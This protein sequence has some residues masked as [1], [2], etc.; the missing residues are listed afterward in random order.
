MCYSTHQ[1]YFAISTRKKMLSAGVISNQQNEKRK[2]VLS[3]RTSQSISFGLWFIWRLYLELY[4]DSLL[5]KFILFLDL[6]P[7]RTLFLIQNRNL[8]Q[9][10]SCFIH[11]RYKK[12]RIIIKY[13]SNIYYQEMGSCVRFN[14]C[15]NPRFLGIKSKF[16]LSFF[17]I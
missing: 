9:Y 7:E 1:F 11:A 13:A 16:I 4:L 2:N 12:W 17:S 3:Y 5:R 6:F 14:D 15:Y 10:E 8:I